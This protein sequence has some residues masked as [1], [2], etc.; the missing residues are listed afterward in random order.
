MPLSSVTLL[1]VKVNPADNQ[2][3]AM[4]V[5]RQAA[6]HVDR[7]DIAFAVLYAVVILLGICGNSLVIAVVWKTR[8]M[9]TATNYLLVNLA[10]SDI[11][12]LLWCPRT[13]N[14]AV[15]GSL[16]KG[17]LG[18]YLCRF[19]VGDPVDTLCLG[20]TLFTLTVLA[21][22]RYQALVTPMR[23]KYTLNKYSVNYAI[24]LIWLLSLAISIPDFVFTHVDPKN[25]ECVSPLSTDV[26]SM[27]AT[28][29]ALAISFYIFL[30][31]LVITFC[32]VQIL[33]GMFITKTICAG[34][35]NGNSEK[36]K[37][38]IL[39][40]A[41][42]VAFYILFLPF[43]V[44]MLHVAF[45]KQY[46]G[47]GHEE[48]GFKLTLV[49]VLTFLIVANS[50]L[51]PVLYAFQSENYRRGFRHLFYPRNSVAPLEHS[52]TLEEHGRI[53]GINILGT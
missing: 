12:V 24:A 20:V 46:K 6:H 35:A 48:S 13:Y 7:T 9:H 25:G 52:L 32:Y 17:E 21:V 36:R 42:T 50:S 30:P 23:T 45:T 37:L 38:A 1:V 3:S 40:I 44:F 43:G 14:F 2:Q 27:K 31:F 33:R 26:N 49:K 4:N 8:S 11:L 39:I 41:V 19:F 5:S 47:E 16:P 51:N 22:E 53:P 29:V 18:D 15:A 34:P 28:Y 10:A